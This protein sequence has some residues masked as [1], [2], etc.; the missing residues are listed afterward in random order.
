MMVFELRSLPVEAFSNIC[1]ENRKELSTR[2][3]FAFSIT[4]ANYQSF[5][6]IAS[7]RSFSGQGAKQLQRIDWTDLCDP[8]AKYSKEVDYELSFW[9]FADDQHAVNTQI[10]LWERGF[11]WERNQ[12]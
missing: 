12:V 11:G 2:S 7:E 8:M 1:S 3:E 6:D 10:W 4:E 9:F 5:D